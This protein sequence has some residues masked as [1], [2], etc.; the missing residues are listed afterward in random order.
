MEKTF[1]RHAGGKSQARARYQDPVTVRNL[2]I[3]PETRNPALYLKIG[4]IS[5]IGVPLIVKDEALGILNLFTKEEH[6]FTEEEVEFLTTLAG[7]AALAIHNASSTR[8]PNGGGARPKSWRAW[9][10]LLQ[11]LWI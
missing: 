6:E 9:R 3:H 1:Y 11:K 7:Q 4:V 8:K 5:F 10:G 2:L